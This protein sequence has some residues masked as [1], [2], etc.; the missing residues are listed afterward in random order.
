MFFD[1]PVFGVSPPVQT[2]TV[3]TLL[4]CALGFPVYVLLSRLQVVDA[5]NPRSSHT[6]PTVRGG[7]IAILLAFVAVICWIPKRQDGALIFV[8][9]AAMAFLSV[10]SFIDDLKSL[11]VGIRFGC[12][13]F[14]GLVA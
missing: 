6:E 2:F 11:P 9:L 5:P 8:L 3:S 4:S 1:A 7:G 13:A 12:Q 10:I 14:V